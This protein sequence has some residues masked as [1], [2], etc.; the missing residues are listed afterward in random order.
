M[1]HDLIAQL[2]HLYAR[3]TAYQA[4][5]DHFAGRTH[6]RGTTT[7]DRVIEKVRQEGG[8]ASR[9]DVIDLFRKLEEIGVGKFRNGRRGHP[10]RFEWT[11][12]LTTVGSVASGESTEV[13]PYGGEDEEGESESEMIT[14]EYKLRPNLTLELSLPEDFSEREAQRLGDF[15]RTLAF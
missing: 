2:R 4:I 5:F 12:Q 1:T 10:S 14:H 15:V 7:V 3:S 13:D 6:N 9:K 8:D 11:S